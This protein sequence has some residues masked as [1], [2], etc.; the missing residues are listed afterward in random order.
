MGYCMEKEILKN[1]IAIVYG[2]KGVNAVGLIRSLGMAGYAVT[3]ASTYSKIESKYVTDYLHLTEDKDYAVQLLQYI[4]KLG[5]KPGIFTTDDCANYLLDDNYVAFSEVS[6][7][8]NAKGNLRMVSDKAV[9]SDMALRCGLKVAEFRKFDILKEDSCPI[10]FPVILKPYAGY[11]GSKGDICIC[12]AES[13]FKEAI[14]QLKNKNYTEVM[15]Q[16]L[17]DSENQY[18]I[19]L[20]GYSLPDGTVEIPCTI[21]KIRSWPSGRGSTSYA[22]IKNSLCNVSKEKLKRFV[23]LTEYIGIFDIE[24]I[25]SEGIPYFVEINYRNGQYGFAPTVAGYNIPDN[26]YKGMAGEETDPEKEVDEIYYINERDDFL[27]VKAGDVSLKQWLREFFGAKAYGMYCRGDQRPYI[28]QYFKIPDRVVIRMDCIKNKITDFLIRE[29]WS[30]AIRKKTGNLLFEDGGC[31]KKFIVIPNSFRYW[32]ADPFIIS[33]GNIDYLFFEMFDRFKGKGVIGYR[34]IDKNGKIGKMRKAYESVHHLSFPFIF[35]Y[36]GN[37]YMMPESSYDKNLTLLRARHFPDDWEIIKTW[38]SG[39]RICDSVILKKG[40][41]IFLLT[42]PIEIP[43]THSKL[44][45]YQYK[46]GEWTRCNISPVVDD[47]RVARMGGATI[48]YEGG[49]IRVSQDCESYGEAINFSHI[50]NVATDSYQEEL[51]CRIR[52][53]DIQIRNG[54]NFGCGIH[55]YNFSKRYEVIDLKNK[56]AVKLGYI[57]GR[58]KKNE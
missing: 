28:R 12:R 11:A 54:S 49:I 3:F 19:G 38:F 5:M 2:S 58:I 21:R 55:T 51:I 22:Q 16:H 44:D 36:H 26:W 18:E 56:K 47:R 17:L 31:R 24:I 13:D 34:S 29:E 37:Y 33:V 27:H 41:N 39:K 10:K 45:L 23:C 48:E 43:Y 40:E 35:E 9:M 32:C 15:V 52:T 14:V 8:P 25:V 1:K 42:Q 6:Y 57:L 20:M 7:C 53:T 50:K 30:I 4:S 46:N